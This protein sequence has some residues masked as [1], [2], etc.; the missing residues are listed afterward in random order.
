MS[1]SPNLV[2]LDLKTVELC[3]VNDLELK[4]GSCPRKI[5]KKKMINIFLHIIAIDEHN[6][7]LQLSFNFNQQSFVSSLSELRFQICLS[8]SNFT[9]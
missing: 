8:S 3:S 4:R 9:R 1:T 5:V 6:V 7:K 2:A